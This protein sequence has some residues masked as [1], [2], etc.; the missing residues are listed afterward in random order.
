MATCKYESD[1]YRCPWE[2]DEETG[3]GFCILHSPN[4]E[5]DQEA[6]AKR[7]AAHREKY[8]DVFIGFVFP[9]TVSF[10]NT[11]FSGNADFT[12]AKF[13]GEAR[14]GGAKFVGNANFGRAAFSGNANFR[15]AT[16]SR[17]G[18]YDATFG[19]ANFGRAVFREGAGF[20][21]AT[22]NGN[23]DF[24]DA[25]FGEAHFGCATFSGETDFFET[26]FNG[27][28]YF[29]EAA[30]D[31]KTIFYKA[32]F[33]GSADFELATFSGSAR[34]RGTE[35]TEAVSFRGASFLGR[36]LFQGGKR[37]QKRVHVFLGRGSEAECDFTDAVIDLLAVLSFR[38]VDLTRCKFLGTDL[39]KVELTD[40]IWA[41]LGRRFGIYDQ[42]DAER[43]G[44]TDEYPFIERLYR[45]IKQNYED[46]R[47]YE[48][49]SDFH[50]GEKEMRRRNPKTRPGL[51]FLLTL[52][53][54]FS[55]YGER[56][57]RPLICGAIL[58]VV[59]AGLYLL[60]GLHPKSGGATLDVTSLWD[61]LRSGFYSFRVMTL[62]RPD[63]LA[64][65]RYAKLVKAFESL[66][67][68]LLIGLAAL[69]IRQR[70]KR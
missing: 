70:L 50:Y 31:G 3:D 2:S 22:F 28:A 49:A 68:P 51:R 12:G 36:T 59:C 40:V 23:A 27:E 11:E 43:N 37:D 10:T 21:D 45:E 18:F 13:S 48:R 5:K 8:G 14:F 25:T 16:F 69:A 64:P 26:T 62:L 65:I 17:V 46:R 52:Y 33:S 54:L 42:L 61:W 66:A 63:D 19:K 57:V 30:F 1:E 34:F 20:L 29:S 44:R 67:G 24:S 39:R 9:A 41:R 53:W 35:F 60:L 32:T 47:D 7:L 4:P 38:G 58:L 55:G 6:F 56:W 15:E